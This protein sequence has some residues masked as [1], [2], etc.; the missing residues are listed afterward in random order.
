MK[1]NISVFYGG[2]TDYN[3][4]GYSSPRVWAWNEQL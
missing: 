3:E 2:L 4:P 1:W